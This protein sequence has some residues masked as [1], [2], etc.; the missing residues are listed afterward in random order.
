[1]QESYPHLAPFPLLARE[2]EGREKA[3]FGIHLS[4]P[5]REEGGRRAVFWAP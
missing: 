5:E 1:M 2:G 3:H 4:S